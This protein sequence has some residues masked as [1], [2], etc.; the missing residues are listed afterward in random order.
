[1]NPGTLKKAYSEMK[2]C[3]VG[4][5]IVDAWWRGVVTRINPE[6][7]VPVVDNPVVSINIGGAGNVLMQLHALG[8]QVY[9]FTVGGCEPASHDILWGLHEHNITGF[10][11]RDGDYI[12]P[13]KIRIIGNNQQLI[14]V[15]Q[16]SSVVDEAIQDEMLQD[17]ADHVSYYH[18]VVLSDYNKGVLSPRVATKMIE[19]CKE[20]DVLVFVN[21]KAPDI[22]HFTGCDFFQLNQQEWDNVSGMDQIPV[23][24]TALIT[25][26][27]RYGLTVWL[28]GK[29]RRFDA[30]PVDVI[31]TSGA[32]DTV[33]A[34][35]ALEYLRSKDVLAAAELANKAG[36]IVVQKP[37]IAHCTVE[38]LCGEV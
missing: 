7:P 34:A 38:E 20:Q 16:E 21:S 9:Y 12:T 33:I 3:V 31:E 27:G 1:M 11:Y 35:F 37:G 23:H 24:A 13:R 8:A 6:A 30:V 26:H 29:A 36:A 10:Y 14:R 32:G 25:T 5:F 28:Q 4:E 18:A 15:D 2:I 19:L 22:K 17:F